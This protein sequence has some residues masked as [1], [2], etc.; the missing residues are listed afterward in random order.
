MALVPPTFCYAADGQNTC[1][2]LDCPVYGAADYGSLNNRCYE[3]VRN[4][5]RL[6]QTLDLK[7]RLHE[8]CTD[9]I[10]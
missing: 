3:R 8:S 9:D 4:L 2:Q 5:I 7:T 10:A 6:E 1:C